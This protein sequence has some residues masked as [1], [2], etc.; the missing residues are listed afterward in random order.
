MHLGQLQI[1]AVVRMLNI[2][3]Q[4]ADTFSQCFP[5][6]FPGIIMVIQLTSCLGNAAV[7]KNVKNK[8]FSIDLVSEDPSVIACDMAHVSI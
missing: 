3:S 2:Y 7:S 1:L 8:V 5:F 6:Y 4:Y